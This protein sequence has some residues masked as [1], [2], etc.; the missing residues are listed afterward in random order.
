M[1]KKTRGFEIV[2]PEHRVH[3]YDIPSL[4]HDEKM[5]LPNGKTVYAGNIQLPT[6]SAKNSAGYDF[7]NPVDI[8]IL[9]GHK[10]LIF[11]DVKAYMQPDE[12][13]SLFIRSSLASKQGLMLSNNVGI[14][15]SDYYNNEGNDGNIGISIVNTSGKGVILRAGERIAQGIFQKFLSVDDDVTT[16]ERKGGFGSSGK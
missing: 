7:Y 11:T 8:T 4:E 12:Y 13:L 15:D 3:V 1:A 16:G 6:R 2:S 5:I 14:I 9:P 10:T